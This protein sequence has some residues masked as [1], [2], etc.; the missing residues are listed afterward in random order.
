MHFI[1]Y[2]ESNSAMAWNL[3]HLLGN[4]LFSL[5]FVLVAVSGRDLE[6]RNVINFFCFYNIMNTFPNLKI[7]IKPRES[8]I[9]ARKCVF[10]PTKLASLEMWIQG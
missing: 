1:L 3:Q 7:K 4:R 9:N 6:S 2:T 8:S 5:N 10:N